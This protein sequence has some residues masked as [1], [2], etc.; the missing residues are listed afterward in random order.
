M[1]END[2]YFPRSHKDGHEIEYINNY[3]LLKK[4]Y[5]N[6]LFL[7]NFLKEISI[8]SYD[9]TNKLNNRNNKIHLMVSL[10]N[11]YIYPLIVSIN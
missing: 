3:K 2:I 1:N 8:T 5:S 9:Y 7:Y 10:N 4:E 6:D 11:K